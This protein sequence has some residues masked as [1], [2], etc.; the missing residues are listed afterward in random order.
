MTET[1]T[2]KINGVPVVVEYSYTP[3]N[4]Q[5]LS[6]RPK[7]ADPGDAEEIHIEGIWFTPKRLK[8][9]MADISSVIDE[10]EEAFLKEQIQLGFIAQERQD[11][12]DM[13]AAMAEAREAA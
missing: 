10:F 3:E 2:T 5:I 9:G 7:D 11:G 4:P 6:G 13:A 1:V 12:E 8:G